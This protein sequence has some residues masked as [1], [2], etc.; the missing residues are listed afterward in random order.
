MLSAITFVLAAGPIHCVSD[1]SHEFT[2]YMDGRFA[3]QYLQEGDVDVRNWGTLHK[4]DLSRVNLL[5]LASGDTRVEYSAKTRRHVQRYVE[6]GGGLVLL[7]DGRA[8]PEGQELP[9]QALSMDYGM[10]FSRE[11][12]K[13]PLTRPLPPGGDGVSGRLEFAGGGVLAPSEGWQVRAV[14]AE[15]RPVLALRKFGK[16]TVLAAT[17]GLF[18]S[19]PDASDPLNQV[20]IRGL[21]REVSAGK[22]VDPAKPPT[23]NFAE[24]T[25]QTGPLTLEY[26]E[27]TEPF[28]ERIA[29]EYQE[30][31][32]HLVAI[33]GVEP[34]PGMITRML[35]LPTGGGGFSSGER[36]AIGAWWGDYPKNRYPMVELIAHEAGHSWVL[37][38]PEPVWNEPIA[39]YLGILVGRRMGMPE[40]DRTLQGA[41]ERARREDPNLD[42]V[43]IGK[44]GAPNAVVWGKTYHLFEEIERLHGP[45]TLA[46]YF[47]TKRQLVKQGRKGYSLDDSVGVWSAA[48][49]KDL[50]PFFRSKGIDVD[51]SRTDL[52]P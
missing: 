33:T 7:G 35:M 10:A 41:I 5:V 37:P 11:S 12:A 23:G 29:N 22:A 50:F 32:P 9:L 40:A 28:V 14:D 2:F 45:G 46:K 52:Y 38:H 15:G 3:R 13:P 49:G 27:G 16:G 1:I 47:Q 25:R 43:D 8:A 36:I 44:E 51:A 18:G 30:I 20:W 42:K 6:E 17:R 48:V 31:R 39:T 34:S 24:L 26:T 4:Q 19:K 21:L